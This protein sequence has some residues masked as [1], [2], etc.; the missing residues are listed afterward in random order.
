[1]VRGL[2]MGVFVNIIHPLKITRITSIKND[3]FEL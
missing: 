1:M 3:R 2:P